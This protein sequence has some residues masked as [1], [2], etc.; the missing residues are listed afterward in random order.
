MEQQNKDLAYYLSLPYTIEVIR[1]N[2]EENPG[3]VA[4]VVE[5]P[6]VITQADTFEELGEMVEDA[7]RGWIEIA[8]EDGI[9]VP[10]P[11]PHEEYSGKFVIRLP[12]SLHRELAEIADRENVSLNAFVSTALGKAV[13]QS[14][15]VPN[16]IAIEVEPTPIFAW[17]KLS[18]QARRI[19]L[20]YGF[21]NEVQEVDEKMFAGW[22]EDHLYQIRTALDQGE[23]REALRY[24]QNIRQSLEM[25]C[26]QSPL[27]TTYCRVVS[28][29]EEQIDIN[30][31]LREGLIEQGFVKSRISA[32]TRLTTQ[33]V[34][35][36]FSQLRNDRFIRETS[37][38]LSEDK[39]KQAL[40]WV[41][42]NMEGK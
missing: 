30:T 10:E 35:S 26:K 31:K 29:L 39:D 33:S 40:I 41:K 25:L 28:L 27:I 11:R 21:K 24:I 42:R 19:L 23:Y 22:I 37:E 9:P 15:V 5:I 38:E 8:I 1:D 13:G 14:N 16:P 18:E 12:K 7:M 6:G 36:T 2:D 4:R 3:W 17:S 32:Q 34:V 20:V